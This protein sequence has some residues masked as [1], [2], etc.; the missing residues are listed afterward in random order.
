[1]AG[2]LVYALV[3]RQQAVRYEKFAIFNES[4]MRE[5]EERA[6]VNEREAMHQ[7]ELARQTEMMALAQA[8]AAQ[9]ALEACSKMKK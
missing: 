1:M 3:Q 2:C 6:E 9:K 5:A 4:K 8:E 7:Q